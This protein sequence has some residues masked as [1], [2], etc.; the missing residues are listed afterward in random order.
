MGNLKDLFK[1]IVETAG[2]QPS[3]TF[4]DEWTQV[5]KVFDYAIVER[6]WY[7]IRVDERWKY[8]DLKTW[9]NKCT[10]LENEEKQAETNKIKKPSKVERDMD[11]NVW[12][13]N[14]DNFL[15]RKI[16][17]RQYL[18]AAV[19]IGQ[20]TMAEAEKDKNM[21]LKRGDSLDGYAEL[22]GLIG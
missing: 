12:K 6:A 22:T 20:M 2:K 5:M 14:L 4:Y 8:F 18:N 11:M 3:A 9:A 16:T 10:Y 15:D 21:Y 19:K 17:R 7:Q 13:Q 1:R